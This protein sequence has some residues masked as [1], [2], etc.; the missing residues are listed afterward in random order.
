MTKDLARDFV[1]GNLS[2]G[3]R[4]EVA[5]ARLSNAELDA[6]IR[7][8]EAQLA[9]LTGAAGD[10]PPPPALFD[11]IIDAIDEHDRELA[12]KTAQGIDEGIWLPWLPGIEA[13]RMWTPR[14]VMLRCQ[15]GAVLP[16]HDHDEDEHIIVVSGDFVVGGRTFRAGDYHCSPKGNPHGN[17]F[18]RGGCLL[19]IQ[20]LA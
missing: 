6:E 1:F 8:F 12:G 19:L 16:A 4:G 7:E 18:T 9:P 20:C 17:A 11:R 3:E 5:R 2:P 10:I 13:R 14:T 15:P